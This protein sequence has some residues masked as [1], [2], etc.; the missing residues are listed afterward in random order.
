ME[1]R[2]SESKGLLLV[3]DMSRKDLISV[4]NNGFSIVPVLKNEIEWRYKDSTASYKYVRTKHNLNY[5]LRKILFKGVYI[6]S[7]GQKV[8]FQSNGDVI[9]FVGY[10]KYNVMFDFGMGI[11]YDAIVFFR[12][13][14]GNWDGA[15]IFKYKFE[16][17]QLIL[18]KIDSNWEN[19]EQ[20]ITT[21]TMMLNKTS[22]N[23]K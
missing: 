15:V 21:E 20:T 7:T 18:T 2:S 4:P 10:S 11:D 22:N 12:K 9:N 3:E 23:I 16:G 19:L 8:T 14:T 6:D 1:I 13:E 5:E 17:S